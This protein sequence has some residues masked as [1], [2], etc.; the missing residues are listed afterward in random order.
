MS[1]SVTVTADRPGLLVWSPDSFRSA[2]PWNGESFASAE[3]SRCLPGAGW[4]SHGSVSSPSR[5]I[6]SVPSFARNIHAYLYPYLTRYLR[7]LN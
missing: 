4:S 1:P 6:S 5:M 7:A 3:S 2:R